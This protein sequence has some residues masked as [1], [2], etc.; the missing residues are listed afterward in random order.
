MEN[1]NHRIIYRKSR[2]DQILTMIGS[3]YIICKSTFIY[4][5]QS[6]SR[7]TS[8][9]VEH[10]VSYDLIVQCK[11]VH[12]NGLYSGTRDLEYYLC[13]LNQHH[14]PLINRHSNSQILKNT[15]MCTYQWN[16]CIPKLHNEFNSPLIDEI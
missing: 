1:S 6:T 7:K 14:N 12:R 5:G 16:N 15:H 11:I 2:K 4:S 9:S 3:I 8:L 10:N 13:T